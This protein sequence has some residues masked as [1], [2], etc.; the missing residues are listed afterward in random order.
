MKKFLNTCLK[1]GH[2]DKNALWKITY[3]KGPIC[4]KEYLKVGPEFGLNPE[5]FDLDTID[6]QL[7]AD[8]WNL[9]IDKIEDCIMNGEATCPKCKSEKYV[10]YDEKIDK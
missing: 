3:K 2:I 4:N 5:H 10:E 8:K 1:C 7:L 9:S 6:A